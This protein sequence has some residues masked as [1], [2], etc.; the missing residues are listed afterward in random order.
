MRTVPAQ[1]ACIFVALASCN[2]AGS[3]SVAFSASVQDLHTAPAIKSWD[4]L[5]SV[6][7]KLSATRTEALLG[8]DGHKG[9]RILIDAWSPDGSPR[10]SHPVLTLRR[11]RHGATRGTSHEEEPGHAIVELTLPSTAKYVLSVTSASAESGDLTLRLVGPSDRPRPSE[12]ALDLTPT[13]SA[14]MTTLAGRHLGRHYKTGAHWSDRDVSDCLDQLTADS[15][16]QTQFSDAQKLLMAA[17]TARRDAP[18]QIT[19]KQDGQITAG[20][21]A[22][23]GDPT[24]FLAQVAESDRPFA[25]YVLT[26]ADYFQ[27]G[28]V[29]WKSL[30]AQGTDA[31]DQVN[32]LVANWAGSG[33]NAPPTVRA[34]TRKGALYGYRVQ[35]EADQVD[36]DGSPLFSWFADEFFDPDLTWLGDGSSAAVLVDAD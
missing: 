5:S 29:A 6:H 13:P 7:E 28:A 31:L 34:Y 15:D 12:A 21:E 26:L 32:A 8:F 23:I 17:R 22:I 10:I 1:L 14:E 16:P 18:P 25:L 11:G 24:T 35:F 33:L 4:Y 3:N 30:S 36:V 27:D 19:A 20:V 9:D 2:P